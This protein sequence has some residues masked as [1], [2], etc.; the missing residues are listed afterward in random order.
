MKPSAHDMARFN[1]GLSPVMKTLSR[2]V[3][4]DEMEQAARALGLEDWLPERQEE[5][6]F[7]ENEK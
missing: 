6:T 7:K 1:R 3:T 2:T 4:E 5:M